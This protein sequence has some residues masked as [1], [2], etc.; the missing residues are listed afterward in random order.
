MMG[1]EQDTYQAA[2]IYIRTCP[3][4]NSGSQWSTKRGPSCPKKYRVQIMTAAAT[5]LFL[6]DHSGTVLC[7]PCSRATWKRNALLEGVKQRVL[8]C[9]RYRFHTC[10][11]WKMWT[12]KGMKEFILWNKMTSRFFYS[13][14]KVFTVA[15]T[16][17]FKYQLPCVHP[18]LVAVWIFCYMAAHF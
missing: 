11:I 14:T 9:F 3:S 17:N 4:W 2:F 15:Y 13:G 1:K 6:Q 8:K 12:E 5:E 16:I 7:R 10:S 18:V